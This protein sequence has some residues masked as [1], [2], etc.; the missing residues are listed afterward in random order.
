M[1]A[2]MTLPRDDSPHD[3]SGPAAFGK[4][5]GEPPKEAPGKDRR[6]Q[7]RR[8]GDR[9]KKPRRSVRDDGI[10]DHALSHRERAQILRVLANLDRHSER[11]RV[12]LK[13]AREYDRLAEINDEIDRTDG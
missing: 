1:D 11:R 7:E 4:R 5:K 9:R 8:K 10:A 6:H 3:K 13:I 2:A 12:L